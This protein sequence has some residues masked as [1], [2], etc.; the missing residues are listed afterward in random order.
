ME[1][2]T[3]NHISYYLAISTGLNGWNLEIVQHTIFFDTCF[4]DKLHTFYLLGRAWPTDLCFKNWLN[5]IDIR[6]FHQTGAKRVGPT[7]SEPSGETSRGLLAQLFPWIY[8]LKV[9]NKNLGELLRQKSVCHEGSTFW[10]KVLCTISISSKSI[11]FLKSDLILA[12][13]YK[14]PF[15]NIQLAKCISQ[16]SWFR[17]HQILVRK[18]LRY[19]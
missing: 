11:S 9:K 3:C 6:S 5:V 16:N 12:C 17:K 4:M 18:T 8:W 15:M 19:Q 1:T 7:R 2:N 13:P 14:V 10:K